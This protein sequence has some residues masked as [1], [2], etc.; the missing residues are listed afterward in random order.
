MKEYVIVDAETQ[1]RIPTLEA[2]LISKFAGMHSPE[3]DRVDKES[4][5]AVFRSIARANR[6]LIREAD[7]RR[8]AGLIW[9]GGADEAM[10]F[11]QI[12]LTDE[13]FP[14]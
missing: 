7:L 12:S 6:D 8:L 1:H 2:A 5:I 13:P 11:V 3:R 10:R 4:D 9:E 14:I